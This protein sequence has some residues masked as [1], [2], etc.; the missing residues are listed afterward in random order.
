MTNPEK[1]LDDICSFQD[2][3]SRAL[4]LTLAEDIVRDLMEE[5]PVSI[6]RLA[7]SSNSLAELGATLIRLDALSAADLNIPSIPGSVSRRICFRTPFGVVC[8][9][10]GL[11]T[12]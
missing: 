4:G 3:C 8:V 7:E 11:P 12:P 1:P 2:A 5:N 6:E 10:V 9:N